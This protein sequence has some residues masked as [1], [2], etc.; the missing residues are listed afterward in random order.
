MVGNFCW[1]GIFVGFFLWR[2]NFWRKFLGIF[3]LFTAF[4]K[5]FWRLG[6]FGVF[7]G[8]VVLRVELVL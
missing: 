4:T 7:G 3:V 5:D 1:L 6:I 2:G 8:L